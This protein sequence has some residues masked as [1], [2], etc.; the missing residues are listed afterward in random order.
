[1]TTQGTMGRVAAVAVALIA[2]PAIA[3]GLNPLWPGSGLDIFSVALIE[4]VAFV[5]SALIL[6]PRPR[7]A[8]LAALLYFP[9]MFVVLFLIGYWTSHY[10]LP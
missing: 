2:P 5:I 4:V 8:V 1:M 7:H 10:D 9:S 6:R 3:Y